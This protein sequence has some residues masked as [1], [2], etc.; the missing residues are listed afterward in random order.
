MSGAASIID[1]G[2]ECIE[3]TDGWYDLRGVYGLLG[4]LCKRD[5][6][7]NL[8]SSLDKGDLTGCL[9]DLIDLLREGPSGILGSKR[10]MSSSKDFCSLQVETTSSS[11][12]DA[13]C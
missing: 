1:A 12:R 8:C 3:D 9:I 5:L 6:S 7:S 2:R 4:L 13:R 10:V 11:L